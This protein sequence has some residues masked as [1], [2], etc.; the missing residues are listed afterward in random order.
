MAEI[1]LCESEL[2]DLKVGLALL[3]SG[4]GGAPRPRARLRSG[5]NKT[6][7]QPFADDD[8]VDARG[9]F[10][11]PRPSPCALPQ[12]EIRQGIDSLGKVRVHGEAR[13][14]KRR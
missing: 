10:L 3:R 2:E 1:Q 8:A 13:V 11:R 12:N 7:A 9:S 14:R 4:R 6:S 5:G